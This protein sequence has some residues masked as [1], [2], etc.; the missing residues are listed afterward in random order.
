MQRQGVTATLPAVP[1]SRYAV[2]AQEPLAL[3]RLL[4]ATCD[5]CAAAQC[6]RSSHRDEQG[7]RRGHERARGEADGD[8]D[9]DPE[10]TVASALEFQLAEY[11]VCDT[12]FKRLAPRGDV[13]RRHPAQGR[14]NVAL[15]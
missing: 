9:A 7:N 14:W 11:V 8:P 2:P 5:V 13:L 6:A 4:S 12:L 3:C 10:P 1:D 15:A